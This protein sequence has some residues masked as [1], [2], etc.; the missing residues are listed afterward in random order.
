[1]V[2]L[3][4]VRRKRTD[5]TRG[6]GADLGRVLAAFV[7][8]GSPG[9]NGTAIAFVRAYLRSRRTLLQPAPMRR[10]WHTAGKRAKQ[11]ASAHRI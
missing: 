1:M 10:I 9:G 6:Q 7:A 3:D 11:W 4:G 8:A 5:D 2:D